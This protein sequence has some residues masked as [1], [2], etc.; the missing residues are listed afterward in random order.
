[1]SFLRYNHEN[2]KN[3]T[4][5]AIKP[6]FQQKYQRSNGKYIRVPIKSRGLMIGKDAVKAV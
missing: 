5:T 1:M 6:Y 3:V 4:E 2:D